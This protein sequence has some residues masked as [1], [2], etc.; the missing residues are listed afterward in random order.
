MNEPQLVLPVVRFL[1]VELYRFDL[2]DAG[3]PTAREDGA[4]HR[5]ASVCLACRSGLLLIVELIRER[6]HHQQPCN[7]KRRPAA[8]A[9]RH[10]MLD[11]ETRRQKNR[12]HECAQSAE[13]DQSCQRLSPTDFAHLKSCN[14]SR[15]I[16]TGGPSMCL[17][18][19]A[20]S[21]V[22]SASS[23]LG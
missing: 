21:L 4:A 16:R 11:D 17:L 8:S 15:G 5:K 10:Q 1:R 23:A 9:V 19:S 7:G 22:F 2:R 20:L 12:S 13:P 14:H 18:F 3:F 6:Q